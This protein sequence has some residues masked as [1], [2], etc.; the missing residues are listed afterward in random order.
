MRKGLAFLILGLALMGCDA[1]VTDF[2]KGG[3]DPLRDPDLKTPPLAPIAVASS[4]IVGFKVSPG[5]MTATSADISLDAT[6]SPTN[7]ILSTT[8]MSMSVTISRGVIAQ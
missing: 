6:V 7:R 2:V 4:D 3:G 5:R 1:S 8:D